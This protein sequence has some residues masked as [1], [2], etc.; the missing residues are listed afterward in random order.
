[1]EPTPNFLNILIPVTAT[2]AVGIATY[3][4]SK[5]KASSEFSADVVRENEYLR[6]KNHELEKD[7]VELARE[8]RVLRKEN[9]ELYRE[10]KNG[11][12]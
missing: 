8:N 2:V 5:R 7:N 10:K 12:A 3:F 11:H 9:L 1:M 6:G 4:V